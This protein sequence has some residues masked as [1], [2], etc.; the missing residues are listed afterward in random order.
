MLLVFFIVALALWIINYRLKIEVASR[1][2]ELQA[3]HNALGNYL[4]LINRY[5]ITSTI[6]KDGCMQVVSDALCSITGYSAEELI[7][8]RHEIL[9]HPD[10]DPNIVPQIRKDL[11]HKQF[12]SGEILYKSKL[13]RKIWLQYELA[14]LLDEH[15][16]IIGYTTVYIDITVKKDIE[17]LSLTDSLTGLPNR[18]QLDDSIA[19]TMATA[20]RHKRPLSIALLD[21]DK[22]KR[23]NDNHGHQVGDDVLKNAGKILLKHTRK[24]DIAGRWGGEEFLIICPETDIDGVKQLA[25]YLRSTIEHHT[26]DK[27]DRQTCSV[28]VAQWT[29]GESFEQLLE[30]TDR[31]L[32]QAKEQGRNRVEKAEPKA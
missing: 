12:W 18:R 24:G 11:D 27:I 1:T 21:L 26:F 19:K 17:T 8:N 30:R 9:Q 14:P 3:A 28:G 10:N 2:S 6:G 13:G 15:G 23:V 29:E 4:K 25:D 22:F 31:A 20:E 5:V 7:G 32:Y 16:D